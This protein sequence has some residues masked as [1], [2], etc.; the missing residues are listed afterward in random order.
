MLMCNKGAKIMKKKSFLTLTV[1][2]FCFV[3]AIFG[4]TA[5]KNNSQ[6][7]SSDNKGIVDDTLICGFN[8]YKELT[9]LRWVNSFGAVELTTDYKT[10]GDNA[11][12]LTVRDITKIQASRK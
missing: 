9:S 10:E 4:F 7:S 6:S 12:K 8:D 3:G 5:C 11:A 2:A 1:A